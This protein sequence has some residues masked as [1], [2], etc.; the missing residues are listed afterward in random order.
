MATVTFESCD[1]KRKKTV[2]A[3]A[4]ALLADL[5][6]DHEAPIPFSCRSAS[7]ATCHINVVSGAELLSPPDDEE[8]SVL[9]SID[10]LPPRSRLAC[11]AKLSTTATG[12]LHVRAEN[13]Y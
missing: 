12:T 11:C 5:C 4:G 8:L 3:P 1:G 2:E 6:D 7:C 10:A 13:E 9:E